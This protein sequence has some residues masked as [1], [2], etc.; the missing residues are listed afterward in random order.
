MDLHV[1][2]VHIGFGYSA[3]RPDVQSGSKV[4]YESYNKII[5]NLQYSNR[6]TISKPGL[7]Y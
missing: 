6:Q 3:Y 4:H 2:R 7:V 1:S 5:I